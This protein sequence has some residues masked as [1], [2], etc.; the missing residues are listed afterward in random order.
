MRARSAWPTLAAMLLLGGCLGF[1][2][3]EAPTAEAPSPAP[4][5]SASGSSGPQP[6]TPEATADDGALAPTAD[7]TM[8]TRRRGEDGALMEFVPRGQTAADWT[9]MASVTR[10]VLGQPA[11]AAK[12]RQYLYQPYR[13]RCAEVTVEVLTQKPA[14][15]GDLID[16]AVLVCAGFDRTGLPDNVNA[17]RHELLYVEVRATRT[18]YETFQF[19]WHHDSI[20]ARDYRHSALFEGEARAWRT[21]MEEALRRGA[22]P[23]S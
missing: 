23:A 7:W 2:G 9:K 11:S 13:E 6:A 12:V 1:G 4:Q 22:A 21:G 5:A 14:E 18:G 3:D 8:V 17:K 10:A 15:T 16:E 20:P 19:A